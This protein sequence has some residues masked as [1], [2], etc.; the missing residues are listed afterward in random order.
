MF[1]INQSQAL[2]AKTTFISDDAEKYLIP[3]EIYPRSHQLLVVQSCFIARKMSEFLALSQA[4]KLKRRILVLS[5]QSL[6]ETY[7]KG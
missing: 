2:E 6:E 3:V 4:R 1:D 5:G 7:E